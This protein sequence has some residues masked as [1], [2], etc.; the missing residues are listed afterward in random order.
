[1]TVVGH[2]YWWE[3]RYTDPELG[4]I[5]ANELHMPVGRT[6]RI[7]EDGTLRNPDGTLNADVIH[8]FWVPR[9]NGKLDMI[10]GRSGHLFLRAD[11]PGVYWG[12]CTE[13]CGLSH[14]NMR[15]K[16]IAQTPEDFD[17]WVRSQRAA[18]ATPK[19]GDPAF[20][21]YQLFA[22]KGCAGCHTV[23]GYS[24]GVVGPNLTH[25]YSRT[26][27]ASELFDMSPANLRKWL[28][29]PP[30]E[31]PGSRMP[32]LNL[33]PDEINQLVAYLETLK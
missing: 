3:Y 12:Q 17:A 25:L 15:L 7:V 19:E 14:A 28:R 20:A 29:D 9:L 4:F 18:P 30:G 2:Q 5:T 11:S 24:K 10:P 1:V 21:G 32:N 26:A 27:F 16:A 13:F 23:E 22:S 33:T 6:L 31:K 8:S